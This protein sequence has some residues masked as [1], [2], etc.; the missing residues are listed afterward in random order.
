MTVYYVLRRFKVSTI[1]TGSTFMGA[2][3]VFVDRQAGQVVRIELGPHVNPKMSVEHLFCQSMLE[4]LVMRVAE[5]ETK[6]MVTAPEYLQ[7]TPV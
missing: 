1:A 2:K 4:I 3:R 5:G 6:L 7:V